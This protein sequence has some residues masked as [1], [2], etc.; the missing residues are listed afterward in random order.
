MQI[1]EKADEFSSR[2]AKWNVNEDLKGYPFIQN[3]HARS[4]RL[5]AHFH[6]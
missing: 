5:N 1:I 2:F 3:Q 4:R 6:C